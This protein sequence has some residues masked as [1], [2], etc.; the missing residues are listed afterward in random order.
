[1]DPR[2]GIS[3]EA[4]IAQMKRVVNTSQQMVVLLG[5]QY[6]SR[7]W[8]VYELSEFVLLHRKS[9]EGRLLVIGLDW[10]AWWNPIN[11][12]RTP[13]LSKAERRMIARFSCRRA[14][15]ERTADRQRLLAEIRKGWGSEESFDVWMQDSMEQ[16]LLW[17]KRE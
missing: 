16:V 3:S 6:L 5:D 13:T 17:S 8:C 14:R 1:M 15:C 11:W 7:L 2:R 4:R 9:L 10:P 12:F